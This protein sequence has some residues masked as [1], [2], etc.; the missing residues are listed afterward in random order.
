[1]NM[2]KTRSIYFVSKNEQSLIQFFYAGIIIASVGFA[3]YEIFGFS[4]GVLIKIGC[5][6]FF[7]TLFPLLKQPVSNPYFKKIFIV[8]FLVGMVAVIRGFNFNFETIRGML[9]TSGLFIPFIIPLV[10]FIRITPYHLVHILKA[11]TILNIIYIFFFIINFQQIFSQSASVDN[12]N[13]WLIYSN[14]FLLLTLNY[15]SNSK[16]IISIITAVLSFFLSLIMARRNM[17]FTIGAYILIGFILNV[18]Y[19][20]KKSTNKA[21][22]SI[23]GLLLFSLLIFN[24]IENTSGVY[25]TF[26]NRLNTDTRSQVEDYF[27][28]DLAEHPMD[29]VFGRGMDANYIAT[30]SS[31]DIGGKRAGIETGYLDI[32]LRIGVI[33]LTL[34]LLIS[35]PAIILGVFYSSNGFVKAAGLFVFVYILEL[36]PAGGPSF[37][38]Y[39]ILVWICIGIC[40]TSKIRNMTDSFIKQF[41]KKNISYI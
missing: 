30:L 10:I 11:I 5:L 2:T 39:Y 37:R 31:A 9:I 12:S 18:K 26:L 7:L 14:G 28:K 3:Y 6:I 40:Y 8:Y 21:M 17:V 13:K 15:Y 4:T 38:L 20:Q 35:L 19:F 32:I 33:G 25:N 27:W 29:V 41:L 23:V 1:M 36:Y 16:K 22:I 24:I 34:F